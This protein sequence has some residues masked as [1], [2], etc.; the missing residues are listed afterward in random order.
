MSPI[1]GLLLSLGA[2]VVV[3][4]VVLVLWALIG[5]ATALIVLLI[6]SGLAVLATIWL[7]RA[8]TQTIDPD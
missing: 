1:K 6:A 3:V 5:P 4:I 8:I 7:V 2:F